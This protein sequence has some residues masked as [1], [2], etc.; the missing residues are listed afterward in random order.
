MTKWIREAGKID[1]W[2][3]YYKVV[4]DLADFFTKGILANPTRNPEEDEKEGESLTAMLMGDV[5]GAIRSKAKAKGLN[6]K[7][8]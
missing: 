8:Y 2:S 4:E 3:S 5:L 7:E 1:S 6:I